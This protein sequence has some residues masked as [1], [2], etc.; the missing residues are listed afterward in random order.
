MSQ[1]EGWSPREVLVPVRRVFGPT[2]EHGA[3]P[4]L[5]VGKRRVSH[6]P[7]WSHPDDVSTVSLPPGIVLTVAPLGFTM[8]FRVLEHLC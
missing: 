2:P 8:S 5:D 6:S 4:S 7:A 3:H 1:R